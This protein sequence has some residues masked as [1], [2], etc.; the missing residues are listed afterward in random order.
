MVW[1]LKLFN[2]QQ[3][4][5]DVEHAERLMEGKGIPL[6]YRGAMIPILHWLES[7]P[8]E[9]LD[10]KPSLWVTYASASAMVGKPI[11]SVEAMLQAAETALRDVRRT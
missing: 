11:S 4:R 9:V 8:T 7:L 6:Q 5:N 1:R 10:A 2:M 3:L